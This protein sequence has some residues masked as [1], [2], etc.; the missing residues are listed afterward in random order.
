MNPCSVC[1]NRGQL[2]HGSLEI[3][4]PKENFVCA[5]CSGDHDI[6]ATCP[7]EELCIDAL[8]EDCEYLSPRYID[9]DEPADMVDYQILS[10]F[11]RVARQK[12]DVLKPD[13]YLK[14]IKGSIDMVSAFLEIDLTLGGHHAGTTN[15][16]NTQPV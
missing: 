4:T 1:G 6:C 5:L 7:S 16:Q 13:D 14:W 12:A 9:P 3:N 8:P 2:C 11:I 10:D 15:I